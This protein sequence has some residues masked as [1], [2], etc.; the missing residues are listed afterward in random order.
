[1]VK[2][3]TNN[4]VMHWLQFIPPMS[5][6]VDAVPA[7]FEPSTLDVRDRNGNRCTTVLL[8]SCITFF[9][10]QIISA[11]INKNDYDVIFF[12]NP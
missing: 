2:R 9:L 7:G 4:T 11:S 6:V 10:L 5:R 8:I 1:M 3:V 12:S